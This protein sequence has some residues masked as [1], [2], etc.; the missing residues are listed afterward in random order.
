MFVKFT[1][2]FAPDI[3]DKSIFVK[4]FPL[5]STELSLVIIGLSLKEFN[6]NSIFMK[7]EEIKDLFQK[8]ES[9]ACDYEGV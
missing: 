7:T 4:L 5:K 1:L 8:F 9:I 2:G 3:F 6:S